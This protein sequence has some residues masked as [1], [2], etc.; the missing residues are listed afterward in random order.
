MRYSIKSKR[1]ISFLAY[2][3]FYAHWCFACMDACARVSES[4]ELE[5]QTSVRWVLGTEPRLSG[6][7]TSVFNL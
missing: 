3:L 5:R 4:L 2:I 7:G 1:F 6:R